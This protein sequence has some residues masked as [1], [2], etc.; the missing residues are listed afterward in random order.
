VWLGAATKT[1]QLYGEERQQRHTNFPTAS[2]ALEV[3]NC[4]VDDGREMKKKIA[5]GSAKN[6]GPTEASPFN[7]VLM[8]RIE[9]PTY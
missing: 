3:R 9:H 2:K 6:K 1:V 5:K 4:I 8:R 7:L